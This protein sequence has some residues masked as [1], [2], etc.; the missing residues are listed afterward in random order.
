MYRDFTNYMMSLLEGGF[1]H[2]PLLVNAALLVALSSLH[3]VIV[4][5]KLKNEPLYNIISGILFGLISIICMLFPF[6]FSPGIFVDLR[7]VVIALG[8]LCCGVTVAAIASSMSCLYRIWM[9]GS[10]TIG[11]TAAILACAILGLTY[12]KTIAPNLAILN[13]LWFCGF[14]III[15]A[16]KLTTLLLIPP[17]STG[18]PLVLTL[19]KSLI[20]LVPLAT[21]ATGLLMKVEEQRLNVQRELEQRESNIR[22]L[23]DSLSNGIVVVD[24]MGNFLFCNPAARKLLGPPSEIAIKKL[25]NATKRINIAEL[26]IGEKILEVQTSK[27]VWDNKDCFVFTIIDI[28]ER[29]KAEQLFLSLVENSPS[30][31]Y[32]VKS[33]RL[34]FVNKMME[35]LTGYSRAELIGTDPQFMVVPEEREFVKQEV[36]KMLKGLRSTPIELRARR[37]NGEVRWCALMASSA[38]LERERVAVINFMDITDKKELEVALNESRNRLE[39]LNELIY[40]LATLEDEGEVIEG[41]RQGLITILDLSSCDFS[42]SDEAPAYVRFKKKDPFSV[43]VPL[44]GI[45]ILHI[46]SRQPLIEEKLRILEVVANYASMMVHRIRLKKELEQMAL[47]DPLTGLYNRHYLFALL[48]QEEKRARRYGHPIGLLMVDVD[49]MKA[50]NDEKGHVV[51]DRVLKEVAALLKSSVRESDIVVRY[52]GDEFLIVLLEPNDNGVEKAKERIEEKVEEYNA[53]DPEVPLSLSIGGAYWNPHGE[54]TLDQALSEA[55]RKMYL[56]KTSHRRRSLKN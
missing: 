4:P 9:G 12:R 31:I 36:I 49:D 28:S 45:G 15:T 46:R 33:G 56:E 18:F 6:F 29:K 25:F 22:I 21:L 27:T 48:E 7:E 51:G 55:D 24:Q 1:F 41:T 19:W 32:I 2:F 40:H 10:G 16:I 17:W 39:K 26:S 44:Q 34:F 42:P 8:S 13:P 30:A 43:L 35:N 53:T 47:H 3:H 52:G 23:T 20:W 50:I 14:G 54:I 37:K 11:D 5:L 38:V